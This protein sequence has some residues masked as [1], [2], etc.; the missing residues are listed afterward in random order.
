MIVRPERPDDYRSIAAVVEAAFGDQQVAQLVE[1]IRA[2]QGYR[3]ELSLVADE[4]GEILG[5]VMLSEL[6]VGDG[7]GLQLSPLAV[8][9]DRQR[10]GVG[11]ALVNAALREAKALREPLVLVEGAPAYYSRFGFRRSTELGIEAPK[12][13][14]VWA[15]QALALGG[16]HPVGRAVYPPPF[17]AVG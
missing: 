4:A 13:A 10:Q 7:R 11:S 2:S 3:P 8:R 12:R 17:D 1:D 6:A 14:P 15:F 5:H 16:E 9:P